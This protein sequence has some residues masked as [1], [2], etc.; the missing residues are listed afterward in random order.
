VRNLE[1]LPG[2]ARELVNMLLEDV[3]R[4]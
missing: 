3:P 2:F 4:P 1:Q